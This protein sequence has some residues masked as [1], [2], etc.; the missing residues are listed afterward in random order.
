MMVE[1]AKTD[2]EFE[3][4][5]VRYIRS[6]ISGKTNFY[7]V[8]TKS[9]EPLGTISYFPNWRKYTFAPVAN[10][11]YDVKCLCDIAGAIQHYSELHKLP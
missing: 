2:L 10:T 5:D 8:Q 4:I 7:T 3:H 1:H 11:V 9:G 6:T